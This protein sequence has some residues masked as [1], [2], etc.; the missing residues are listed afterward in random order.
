[1]LFTKK[2]E[3]QKTPTHKNEVNVSEIKG[4]HKSLS[5]QTRMINDH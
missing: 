3:R 1:M 2:Q 5:A 4:D